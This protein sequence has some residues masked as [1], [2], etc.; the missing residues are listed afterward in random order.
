MNDPVKLGKRIRDAADQALLIAANALA[1]EIQEQPAVRDYLA[2]QIA[3]LIVK[4][5]K[6]PI[7]LADQVIEKFRKRRQRMS[8]GF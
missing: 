7:R 4:G 3:L 8:R 2:A 6:N 1:K 5:G